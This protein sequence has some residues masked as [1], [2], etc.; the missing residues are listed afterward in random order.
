V[1][2]SLNIWFAAWVVFAAA[3]VSYGSAAAQDAKRVA[4]LDFT[5]PS[6]GAVQAQVSQ[7]LKARSE[8]ELVSGREVKSTADRLGNSLESATEYKEVGE[9]LELSAFVEG[10]VEKR[11]RNLQANVTVR[12]AST[13]EVIHEE[14]WSKRRSGL[15]TIKPEVWKKLGPAIQESS[16]PVKSKQKPSKAK[17]KPVEIEEEEPAPVARADEEEEEETPRPTRRRRPQREEEEEE[18]EEKPTRSA[19]SSNKS[20]LHPALTVLLGP[21]IMWRTLSYQGDTNLNSYKSNDEGSPSFNLALGAQYFPG[22]HA[23]D[24]WY[25]DLGLDVD[26]DYAIGLKSKQAGK[27][28]KTTAYEVGAG[29]IYRIPLGDFVPRIRVGYI[30]HV[31]DVDV[32]ATVLLPAIDYTA[33]RLGLGTAINLVE[34]LSL[35]VGF[36]YLP[37]LGTGELSEKRYGDKVDTSAWEA[38]AGVLVRLKDA[39]GV[40]AGLDFRRYKYDFGLSNNVAIQLPTKGTDSYLRLTV[41]FVYNMPGVAK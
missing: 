27:E 23:S 32:P 15:K 14:T 34:W 26:L 31:F 2:R 7:G 5:G 40:R 13:G 38:G 28:L 24:A 11:G 10:T 18:A 1:I 30:K 6:A 33:I 16:A 9:A 12:N 3:L 4:V 19:R 25:S 17:P 36:A 29:L 21:R 41:A 39:Y 20:V 8:L 35:D 37:V 22:A